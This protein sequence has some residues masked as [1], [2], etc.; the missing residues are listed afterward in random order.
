MARRRPVDFVG[1]RLYR[2]SFV[3]PV[4]ALLVLL[5][6]SFRAEVPVQGALPPTLANERAAELLGRSQEFTALFPDR[7]PN[8]AG[9]VDSAQWMRDEFTKVDPKMRARTAPTTTTDPATG[10]AV[11]LVNVEAT[12]PGRTR[13]L[14]VIHA[15]R[16]TADANGGASDAVGQ[17]ALLT[18]ARELAATRDRRRTYLFVS[19]DGATLNG[20]GAR[21]LATRLGSR[22]AVVAVIGLD[23]IG[24]GETLRVDA[25]PSGR[26]APPLGLVQAASGSVDAEG[27]R[28]TL[29]G[30]GAQLV[31][32][33][34]PITLREHG[35]LLDAGLPALTITAADDGLHASGDDNADAAHVGAGLRAAQRLIGTLDGV[36]QLQS[37]GKTWVATDQRVYRGWALKILVASL[38]VPVWI[39]AVD[40]LVRHRRGWNLAA[41]VGTCTRAMLAGVVAIGAL[42]LL[43]AFGLLPGT[44]DHPP[45]PGRLTDVRVIAL[46]IWLALVAAAW[47]L[48]RGPDWRRQRRASARVHTGPD[49]P[50]IVVSLVGLVVVSALALS[51]NPYAVLFV[52]PTLHAWMCVAS[53]R[54]VFFRSRAVLVWSVGLVGPLAALLAVGA[55]SDA[56][57]GTGWYALQ[58]VQTRTVPPTLALL[59]GAG[60]G[61]AGLLLVAAVGRVAHPALPALRARVAA[62]RDGQLGV[63]AL[64]PDGARRAAQV[65]VAQVARLRVP[66]TAPSSGRS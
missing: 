38:L 42:W 21:A 12:L 55:R 40:M 51:V 3:V 16:D 63:G 65:L 45:N 13:E 59:I 53:W 58:L 33:A 34:T 37:A 29:G 22:G 32:L 20:G 4:L 10:H 31:R 27:G 19:T 30:I 8:T 14:V 61:L 39:G 49:T 17:V 11:T 23:R 18:L 56:G 15:H 64:L 24:G 7:R 2:R 26:H 35:Q 57:R 47:L 5:V 62:V 36:D 28:A 50:E 66:G 54:V 44:V 41:A 48:A 9:D 25:S 43:G 1:W 52:V 46:G 6:T 60:A